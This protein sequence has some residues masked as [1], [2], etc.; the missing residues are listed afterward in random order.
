[1]SYLNLECH[2]PTGTRQIQHSRDHFC[3]GSLGPL[4]HDLAGRGQRGFVSHLEMRV[5]VIIVWPQDF[6][7][8]VNDLMLAF[9][10]A[11]LKK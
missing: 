9:S 3:K 1:M 4:N 6:S 11:I 10:R 7:I 8:K 5:Q 2:F